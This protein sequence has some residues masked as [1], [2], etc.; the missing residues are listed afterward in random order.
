MSLAQA[1]AR[2]MSKIAN[3]KLRAVEVLGGS[4]L[5]AG[6]GYAVSGSR[7]GALAGAGLGAGAGFVVSRASLQHQAAK[8]IREFASSKQVMDSAQRIAEGPQI[9]VAVRERMKNILEETRTAQ[10]ARTRLERNWKKLLRK[11]KDVPFNLEMRHADLAEYEKQLGTRRE[12]HENMLA[13]VQEQTAQREK[14]HKKLLEEAEG[15][16]RKGVN[17]KLF[18]RF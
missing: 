3:V 12:A 17:A 8:K 9:V 10:K 1:F 16:I 14:V 7:E 13:L 18:G 6:T 2:E 15:K 11:R 5:G 4:A